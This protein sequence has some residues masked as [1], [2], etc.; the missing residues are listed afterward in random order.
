MRPRCTGPPRRRQEGGGF[1]GRPSLLCQP[2]P[3]PVRI[4]KDLLRTRPG[5]HLPPWSLRQLLGCP[6]PML[7]TTTD[8][9]CTDL[10]VLDRRPIPPTSYPGER[11][12]RCSIA[13]KERYP[14]SG[15]QDMYLKKK[16]KTCSNL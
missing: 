9:S 8:P 7:S 16:M 4:P 5:P 6:G 14:E 11:Y 12:D 2:L 1:R 15:E 3:R 13:R 10:Q